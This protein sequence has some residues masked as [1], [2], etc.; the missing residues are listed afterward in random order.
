MLDLDVETM[1]SLSNI[2]TIKSVSLISLF[3]IICHIYF[4]FIFQVLSRMALGAPSRK[5]YALRIKF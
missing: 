5:N 2:V 4:V 1:K 3:T